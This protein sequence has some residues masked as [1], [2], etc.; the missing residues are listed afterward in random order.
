MRM[1]QEQPGPFSDDPGK[2]ER[3]DKEFLEK[4]KRRAQAVAEKNFNL[5]SKNIE[6]GAY[7]KDE[8]LFIFDMMQWEKLEPMLNNKFEFISDGDNIVFTKI[9]E[10]QKK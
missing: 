8:L 3:F 2:Q 1:K 9:K 5:R 10:E 7:S 6:L 4:A